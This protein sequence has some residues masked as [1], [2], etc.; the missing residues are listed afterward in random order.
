VRR[1]NVLSAQLHEASERTGYS[2]RAAA[3]GE[4]LGGEEIGARLYE[5]ADGE[6][7]APYHF[8]HG[9]EEWLIVVDGAPLV[10]TP[11]G[12]RAHAS[13]DVVC[14][15]IGPDGAHQVT[16]PGTVLIVST[17]RAPE[18]VE[19]P[20]S[21]KLELRPSGEVFRRADAVDLWEGE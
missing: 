18:V 6:R 2:W 11:A 5:L 14:F 15:P 17:T 12:E 21:G 4:A 20:D 7:I 3:V 16:G 8:H 9:V 13:G 1:F 19:Y 10:R